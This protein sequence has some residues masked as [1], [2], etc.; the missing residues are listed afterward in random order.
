MVIRESSIFKS[1][2]GKEFEI[3]DLGEPKYFLGIE[4]TMSK[5]GIVITR[6][7]YIFHLLKET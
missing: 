5:K 6:L 7:N 3:K 2:L 1:Y 4:A